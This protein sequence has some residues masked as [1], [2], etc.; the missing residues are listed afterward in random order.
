M[1]ESHE[2]EKFNFELMFEQTLTFMEIIHRIDSTP[3]KKLGKPDPYTFG[4]GRIKN[5][6]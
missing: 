2:M 4:L 5:K 6:K 3:A 1:S